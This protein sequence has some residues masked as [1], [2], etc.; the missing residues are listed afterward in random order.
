MSV[1]LSVIIPGYKTDERTWRRCLASVLSACESVDEVIC[2]DDG[3]PE[4]PV[5]L[6]DLATTD[7]RLKILFLDRNVGQAAARNRGLD[8]ACGKY[9]TFVD[10]DDE[11]VTDI[12][13]R[14]MSVLEGA[15]RDIVA[16]GIRTVYETEE[17]A[18][19][20]CLPERDIAHF[21]VEDMKQLVELRLFDEPV[22]KVYRRSFL[23]AHRI[24]FP[25]GIC[26]GE[27]A[28]FVLS[29]IMHRATW[30]WSGGIGYIYYRMD[31]TTLSRYLPNYETTLRFWKLKWDEYLAT[32]GKGYD[33]W[34]P[35]RDYSEAWVAARQ[36]ENMWRRGSPV[37]LKEK[38]DY[39]GLHPELA[40][41]Y[42][43]L[44][45]LGIKYIKTFLRLHFYI[46]PIRRWHLKRCLPNLEDSEKMKCFAKKEDC[47]G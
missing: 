23:D 29:C 8:V 44:F 17:L 41:W 33:G 7:I 4:Q 12:Y 6:R 39:L 30:S 28:M 46:R 26:P 1:R 16:F 37:Q 5:F 45:A 14:C 38:W 24:R 13:S 20:A 3:S 11:I 22:N 42:G 32:E 35:T 19:N 34:W 15:G 47:D 36:W 9:V 43:R 31:G 2:V 25:E 21:E 18:R 27:D 40:R 10:S